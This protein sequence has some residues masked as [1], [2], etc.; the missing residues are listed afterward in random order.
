MFSKK[1]VRNAFEKGRAA[2][3]E[4]E[5]SHLPTCLNPG[6]E[7]GRRFVGSGFKKDALWT[8]IVL[9]LDPPAAAEMTTVATTDEPGIMERLKTML[10]Q[11]FGG[12]PGSARGRC[13]VRL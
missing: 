2:L 3:E 9:H 6:F 13:R 8:E 11:Y 4:N 5:K 7:E 12:T 10:C 1:T